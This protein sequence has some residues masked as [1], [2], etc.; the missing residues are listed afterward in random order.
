MMVGSGLGDYPL[1]LGEKNHAALDYLP[2]RFILKVIPQRGAFPE[3]K[4]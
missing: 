1:D 3:G 4:S 2:G